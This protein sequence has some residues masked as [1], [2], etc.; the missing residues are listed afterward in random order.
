[1]KRLV[2]LS[3][4]AGLFF[5]LS[6][7]ALAKANNPSFVVSKNSQIRYD[8][9]FKVTPY[10]ASGAIKPVAGPLI[11]IKNWP[12][13]YKNIKAF[14]VNPDNIWLEIGAGLAF[15]YMLL[16]IYVKIKKDNFTGPRKANVYILIILLGIMTWTIQLMFVQPLI[17][18][19]NFYFFCYGFPYV[20]L[21]IM[22]ETLAFFYLMFGGIEVEEKYKIKQVAISQ[23]YRPKKKQGGTS[24]RKV[25]S[26]R[27]NK[28]RKAENASWLRRVF[29]ERGFLGSSSHMFNLRARR[30]LQQLKK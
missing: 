7:T 8:Q 24:G 17:K 20:M 22:G 11:R 6:G 13:T 25:Q 27:S 29:G 9:A 4:L 21:F 26:H 30:L 15:I 12:K 14:V 18:Q 28:R 2:L 5:S 1:M 3:L 23:I 19:C 10:K 16:A